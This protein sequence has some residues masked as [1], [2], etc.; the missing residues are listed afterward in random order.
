MM[1]TL[2]LLFTGIFAL[3]FFSCGEV[4][5]SDSDEGSVVAVNPVNSSSSGPSGSSSSGPEG[6]SGS[7]SSS[8]SNENFTCSGQHCCNGASFDPA[9]NF[10][11][12]D[13]NHP[14]EQLYPLCGNKDYN[15]YEQGC[16]G[17]SL[18]PK[19]ELGATRGVCVYESLLRC[20]QEGPPE[21][22]IQD[23]RPGMECQPNGAITGTIKDPRD[24]TIY[25]TVQINNQIWLAENLHFEPPSPAI[26]GEFYPRNSKCH[27]KD[28]TCS[29]GYLRM[30][31]QQQ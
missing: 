3:F 18:Y 15:P 2:F 17:G 25:K 9:A 19:C 20:R 6:S 12:K 5:D 1:R 30:I 13:G 16:F 8:S 4:G 24:Q 22:H 26:D 7:G 29:N 14:E 27:A 10:C 28:P 31:G 21:T 11:Y 23:A